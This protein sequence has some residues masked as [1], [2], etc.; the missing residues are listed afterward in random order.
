M[1]QKALF[2]GTGFMGGVHARA[3][4]S[5]GHLVSGFVGTSM[6]KA[7]SL[8]DNFSGAAAFDNL[9]QAL[10][11]IEPDVVHVCTPN[12]LHVEHALQAVD[13]GANVICE[14]PIATNLDDAERLV[15]TAL[16][17]GVIGVVPFVYRFYAAVQ[18]IKHRVATNQAGE[19]HLLHGS[20]LQDWLA[21]SGET[22][23]RV[24]SEKGGSS[25][26][27]ADIGVHWC[28]L[29]E[30]ISG[31]QITR[32]VATA[33][34][35]HGQRQGRAVNTEDSVSVVFETNRGARGSL[36][37]S[38]VSLGRKNRIWIEIDGED[39]SFTF[40]HDAP[41]TVLIGGLTTNTLLDTGFENLEGPDARRLRTVPSGHP[42]GYLD[43]FTS[44]MT[45]AYGW[46]ESGVA[47]P[48]LPTL[49]DGLRAVRLTEAVMQSARS[50]DWVDLEDIVSLP[51][52]SI[53]GTV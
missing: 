38:Q 35:A 30:H 12:F 33:S 31:H 15:S 5:A 43:A 49:E 21:D 23:W 37:V 42:Q 50:G 26:A 6:S 16:A 36:V 14:K 13:F 20:Y 39:A 46:F 7:E 9:D 18:E 8:A 44:L 19:L 28:D 17:N 24:D 34:T 29:V 2:I 40:D 4:R 25:R 53:V 47:D 10:K 11:E 52:N 27:F 22:N 48:T 41:N 32:L 3:V 51:H 1:M 45:T